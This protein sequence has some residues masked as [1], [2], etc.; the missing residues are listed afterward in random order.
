MPRIFITGYGVVCAIGNNRKECLDSLLA[1]RT[2][3]GKMQYLN[4]L[5]RELPVG[6]V[7][8]SDEEMV[9]KL[10]L[11]ASKPWVR[12]SLMG[13]WALKEA[14]EQS[15]IPECGFPLIN[16]TTVGGMDR[17][18]RYYRHH[19]EDDSKNEYIKC[20]DCGA[21]SYMIA[22]AFDCFNMVSTPSTACSSAMNSIIRGA[23]MILSG[24]TSIVAAGGSESLSSFHTNGF[25][26]LMI[27]DKELCR[28]FDKTRSGLNLGEGAA[29]FILESEESVKKRGVK[30]LAELKGFANTCDAF[31][32]TASS[33]DGEGAYLA[34]KEALESAGTAPCEVDWIKAHGT[35]T[36][37]N[38]ASETVSIR[39][40]FGDN[41]P[42]VSSTKAFTGHTTSASGSIEAAFGLLAI[43]N[44]FIPESLNW[45]ESDGST[46]VPYTGKGHRKVKNVLCN[47]FGFGGN[48]SS[49]LLSAIDEETFAGLS[50]SISHDNKC[51]RDGEQIDTECQ[52]YVEPSDNGRD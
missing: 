31:H 29:Y 18:E 27:L 26:S 1:G 24:E 25:N 12:T 35:G 4:T 42:P 38:D 50:I 47:A 44:Q 28:P 43:E 7:K 36:P 48:D 9:E 5:H 40:L 51:T 11:D 37:N 45:K 15:G 8:M 32:Q 33:E 14:L 34:M 10:G 19:I 6:E 17:S 23:E 21:V 52:N 3:V 20:H 49:I 22:G 13:I 16:G 2:G 30:P 39:R 41:H 46:L